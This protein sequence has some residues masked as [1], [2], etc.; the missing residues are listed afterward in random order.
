[1]NPIRR[2]FLQQAAGRATLL[3]LLGSGL[4]RPGAVLAGPRNTAAFEAHSLAEALKL[5]GAA[6]GSPSPEIQLRLPEIAENGAVV[7][8]EVASALPS[9]RRISLLVDKNPMPLIFQMDFAPGVKPH[10]GTRI[11]MAETSLVRAVVEAGGKVYIAQ[12]EVQVTIGGC[13]G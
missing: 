9:T 4:L 6:D 11:K 10:I 3:A 2:L 13:G 8:V 5:I 12:R 7:S 1:M